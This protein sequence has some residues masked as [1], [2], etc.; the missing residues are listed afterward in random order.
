MPLSR[1][2]TN[3]GDA[4][5]R[6]MVRGSRR[7]CRKTRTATSSELFVIMAGQLSV[8]SLRPGRSQHA[9]AAQ[10]FLAALAEEAE[11]QLP[12]LGR[13]LPRGP[14]HGSGDPVQGRVDE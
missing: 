7:S 6:N 11:H 5:N 14:P 3:V 2:S 9:A 8:M 12:D 1:I 4:M 10:G 13:R